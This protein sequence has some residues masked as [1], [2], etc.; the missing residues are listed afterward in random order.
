[1]TELARL[2][3]SRIAEDGPISV[4]EYM[5]LCLSH[6]EHGYYT[7]R[8]P[9]GR[10]G[11]FVT[12][13]EIS[14]MFGEMVGVWLATVWVGAGRPNPVRLVELGPGRGTMMADALRA[15][16]GAGLA[17]AA[18]LWLVETSPVLRAAQEERL[19]DASWA[20]RLAEVPEGP[21][22]LVA[23]E[24]F[25][26]L[27]VRQFLAS[28]QGWRERLVG[29]ADGAL[30]FGLSAP[31]PGPA[32][33]EGWAEVSP[34]AEAV[35]GEI[36]QRLLSRGGAA[37]VIDYGYGAA[38]RPPGPTLQAVCD[39]AKAD[40]LSAPGKADLTWL[41]D[42]ARL[43]A[44]ARPARAHLTTQGGFLATMGI[45]TRA[46]QLAAQRPERADRL[47]DA[48]ERLTSPD[49]MGQRFKALA[50]LP[51]GAPPPPGFGPFEELR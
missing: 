42:F 38:D 28:P 22:L 36:A 37:L 14:Q 13:P 41:P 45:G 25:D 17:D 50:L 16:R 29:L 34:L 5:S 8:D 6:P 30:A 48:L 11:D 43:A 27:P 33:A 12:A 46:A 4:A 10:G 26:A 44:A 51:P 2:I 35:L 40:P 32:P 23:N 9:F 3:R 18:D 47:A 7:T 1:M 21:M 24:F 15:A 19:P 31:L 49:A 39:H 20:A